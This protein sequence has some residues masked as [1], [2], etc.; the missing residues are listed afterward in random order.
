VCEKEELILVNAQIALLY[1]LQ[2]HK[3]VSGGICSLDGGTEGDTG[4]G[5]EGPFTFARPFPGVVT[6]SCRLQC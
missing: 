3:C 1:L 4:G 2:M 6:P 5:D